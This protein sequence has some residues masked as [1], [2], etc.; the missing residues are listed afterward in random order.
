MYN[1]K[2]FEVLFTS[3]IIVAQ[4]VYRKTIANI[5][6]LD[7]SYD[8]INNVFQVY[9]KHLEIMFLAY[10]HEKKEIYGLLSHSKN[11]VNGKLCSLGVIN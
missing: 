9:N 8:M 4:Y 11:H 6:N 10:S 3:F 2:V 5:S 7:F 1:V